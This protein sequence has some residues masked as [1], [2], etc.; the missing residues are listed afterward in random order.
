MVENNEEH[1]EPVETGRFQ[2]RYTWAVL[3]VAIIF[4]AMFLNA[5]NVN[6]IPEPEG[7]PPATSGDFK[8]GFLKAKTAPD[9]SLF[10]V[11]FDHPQMGTVP[12]GDYRTLNSDTIKIGIY[13]PDKKSIELTVE[14]WRTEIVRVD[15]EPLKLDSQKEDLENRIT[16]YQTDLD[17]VFSTLSSVRINLDEERGKLEALEAEKVS[18]ALINETMTRIKELTTKFISLDEEKAHISTVIK[19]LENEVAA[20]LSVLADSFQTEERTFDYRTRDIVLTISPTLDLPEIELPMD[21]TRRD[22]RILYGSK[23]IWVGQHLT[24]LSH[25]PANKQTL[26]ERAIDRMIYIFGGLFV[27]VAAIKLAGV[28]IERVKVVPYVAPWQALVALLVAGGVILIGAQFYIMRIAL[29][30]AAL[31]YI[32]V[33]LAAFF[34][35]IHILRPK[36]DSWYFIE[37]HDLGEIP[38]ISIY[39]YE[40]YTQGGETLLASGYTWGQFIRGH[41][42]RLKITA[43]EKQPLWYFMVPNSSSSR[44]YYVDRIMD[45]QWGVSVKLTGQHQKKIEQFKADIVAM[46]DLSTALTSSTI[47]LTRL[48]ADT[49]KRGI[50]EGARMAE[51]YVRKILMALHMIQ[52][53]EEIKNEPP[54]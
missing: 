49:H 13:S 11:L 3:A 44:I 4:G 14:S 54:K 20:I 48:K 16:R 39:V 32:P 28:L 10:F 7:Y 42:N 33:S 6:I 34:F 35:G 12:L 37:A 30:S 22:Y 25:Q 21:T 17:T 36:Y 15:L 38:S 51:V 29:R 52:N 24:L 23:E 9:K 19:G 18:E 40:V 45:D 2:G 43:K 50:E 26:G 31:T 1:V 46:T 47:E 27:A 8:G 5:Y 41:T 53:E